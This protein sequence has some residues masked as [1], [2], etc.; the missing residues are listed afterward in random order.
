MLLLTGQTEGKGLRKVRHNLH[1]ELGSSETSIKRDNK[2]GRKLTS[3]KD[4]KF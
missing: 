2:K 3:T 4:I 1:S